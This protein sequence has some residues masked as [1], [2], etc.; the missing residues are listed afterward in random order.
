MENFSPQRAAIISPAAAAGALGILHTFHQDAPVIET[1]H[2]GDYL[3]RGEPHHK[4][5]RAPLARSSAPVCWTRCA[6]SL[7][8]AAH[9]YFEEHQKGKFCRG[10]ACGFRHSFSG[11]QWLC[12]PADTGYRSAGHFRRTA[13]AF[14]RK[15][16]DIRA[17]AR[18]GRRCFCMKAWTPPEKAELLCSPQHRRRAGGRVLLH[19]HYHPIVM[20]FGHTF[21]GWPVWSASALLCCCHGTLHLAGGGCRQAFAAGCTFMFLLD[22]KDTGCSC[23]MSA[24]WQG[25]RGILP[26]LC[27]L[28]WKYSGS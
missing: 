7:I 10:Q 1:R 3:V 12:R 24:C 16:D 11:S 18:C 19:G 21:P 2:A 9:Q 5:G 25:R 20:L 14:F 4:A 27:G 15:T 17:N 8:H 6:P 23:W 28:P 26:A 13:A 22:G